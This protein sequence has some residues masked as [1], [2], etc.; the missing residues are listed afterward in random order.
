[1]E[2]WIRSQD[3]TKLVKI[4]SLEIERTTIKGNSKCDDYDVWLGHYKT[5]ERALQ[6][7]DE[8]QRILMP[9]IM[10]YSPIVKS[11]D[12]KNHC[13]KYELCGSEIE[14][15]VVALPTYVYEMPK[16]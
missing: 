12:L 10:A 2:L 7:L 4:I 16:E 11:K 6:V 1:M 15:D 14:Y 5:K 3:K 9:N 13:M 8:I